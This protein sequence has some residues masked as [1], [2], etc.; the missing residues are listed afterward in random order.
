MVDFVGVCEEVL[1]NF[2]VV[3]G[4]LNDELIRGRKGILEVEVKILKLYLLVLIFF[5][6]LVLQDGMGK[7]LEESCILD[8]C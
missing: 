2:V 1:F 8:F 3:Y 5:L 6:G 7:I 4:C